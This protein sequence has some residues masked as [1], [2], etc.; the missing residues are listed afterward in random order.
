MFTKASTIL[1]A[2]AAPLS[3]WL[4]AQDAPQPVIVAASITEVAPGVVGEEL[5]TAE[6]ADFLEGP[7]VDAKISYDGDRQDLVWAV[8]DAAGTTKFDA[9]TGEVVEMSW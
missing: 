5:V 3:I 1:T 2:I 8:S 6:A 7:V 4:A 9:K